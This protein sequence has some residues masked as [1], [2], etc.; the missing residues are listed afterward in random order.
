[1][2]LDIINLNK[3]YGHNHAV[4]NVS[5]QLTSGIW[6][7]IGANGAGKTTLMNMLAG[8]MK[9]SS[10]YV[11]YDGE[12]IGDMGK[13]YRDILGYLPQSF[14]YHVGF[15]VNDY[16]E[17]VAALKGLDKKDSRIR[18]DE[19]LFALSISDC[20]YKKIRK[21]SGGMQRRVGIAQSMLNKPS[22]LILDEPTSGLDPGERV[23]FRNYISEFAQNRIV[24]ISTHIV[25]DVEY[26]AA[27][28]MIMKAGQ[29]VDVGCTDSLLKAIS[30]MVFSTEISQSELPNY[31]KEVCIV[32][33]R[34]EHDK[35]MSIR[36]IANSPISANSIPIEPR[37][38]DLYVWLFR[39]Y[40]SERRNFHV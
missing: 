10:G 29:I 27:N 36:Y 32:S 19:L 24:I 38:E 20:K 2:E 40:P 21:L 25:S 14:G 28:N 22:V 3:F 33:I 13:R 1:M 11:L 37:L 9:P 5:L 18:I 6:G 4:R 35:V 30:G 23:R 39:D 17:Y 16:L 12:N 8:I 26:I 7:L 31:E 34:D 15:T